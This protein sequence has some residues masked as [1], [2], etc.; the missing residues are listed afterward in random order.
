MHP[1]TLT[2]EEAWQLHKIMGDAFV[3]KDDDDI[4]DVVDRVF[5]SMPEEKVFLAMELLYGKD[6]EVVRPNTFV[7]MLLDGL[8]HNHMAAFRGFV[9]RIG[10]HA[11]VSEPT[12]A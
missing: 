3:V 1:R 8:I 6:F 12:S 4:M 7:S 2:L 11:P 9:L 5:L 10:N